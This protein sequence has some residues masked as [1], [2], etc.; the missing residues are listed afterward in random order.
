MAN[1]ADVVILGGGI[2]GLSSAYYLAREGVRVLL[3]DKGDLGQEASWA[4]A[5]IIP[6]GEPSHARTP[7]EQLRAQS[8]AAFPML[9][10]D[11]KE[12][13][14]IDNGYLRCGGLEF[15]GQ[16]AD[17]AV[18]E[19]RGEGVQTQ[20]LSAAETRRLEPALAEGL[21]EALLLPAMAQVRNPW[22]L[23][24]LKEACARLGVNLLPNHA[25][26]EFITRGSR[27]TFP[28]ARSSS[29]RAPGAINCSAGSA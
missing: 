10:A 8:S 16:Q 26:T 1:S 11:L 17:A 2:I 18:E 22:H 12:L 9:A 25:A 23:R 6:P 15:L 28:A 29:P 27:A 3:L 19:W 13:T 14:G 4:G 5:G 7:L 21:G 20:R 24:A